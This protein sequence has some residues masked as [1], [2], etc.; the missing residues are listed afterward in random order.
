MTV[1]DLKEQLERF[2]PHAEVVVADSV[3]CAYRLLGVFVL[4]GRVWLDPS[5]NEDDR[6]FN[7]TQDYYDAKR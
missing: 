1:S 3:A 2:S 4:N 7:S 5:H 6:V